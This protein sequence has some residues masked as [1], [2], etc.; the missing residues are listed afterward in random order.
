MFNLETLVSGSENKLSHRCALRIYAVYETLKKAEK[1][2]VDF[3]LDN[4]ELVAQ[5]PVT[6]IAKL[7]DCSEATYI[8]LAKK[9]GYSGYPEMKS[10]LL[11]KADEHIHTMYGALDSNDDEISVAT[12]VFGTSVQSL[13]DTLGIIDPQKYKMALEIMQNARR[14]VFLGAGDA[15]IVAYSAYMKFFRMGFP[16]SCSSDLDLQLIDATKMDERDVMIVISHSGETKSVYQ[17]VQCAKKKNAKII[18][19][20]NYPRSTIGK[21]SDVVL[22]TA[23]F[24]PDMLGEIITKRIPELC[25]IESLYINML[26]RSDMKEADE[27]LL[28]NKL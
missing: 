21:H 13:N 22:Q 5:S 24:V 7:A 3:M 15:Y 16:A 14:F 28:I 9:L 17:V 4:A 27:Y 11:R 8:R 1:K 18:T 26:I 23:A 25:M 10:D 6:E 2:A 20:S 19:I 12:K